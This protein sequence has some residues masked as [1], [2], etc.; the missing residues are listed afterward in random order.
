MRP[1]LKNQWIPIRMIASDFYAKLYGL[2][3]DEENWSELLGFRKQRSGSTVSAADG[4]IQA[5]YAG[6]V[7][8]R[9]SPSP[10]S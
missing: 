1:S 2:T 3:G 5:E 7:L 8:K 10:L 4:Q 6:H 9:D